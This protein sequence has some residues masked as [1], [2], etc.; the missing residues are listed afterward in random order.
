MFS[1]IQALMLLLTVRYF[2]EL[3]GPFAVQYLALASTA[4]AGVALG[5]FVSAFAGTSERAMTILPVLLIAQAILSG[6]L[7]RLAGPVKWAAMA[8]APAY[9]ALEG[10]KTS[11][12]TDLL[13]ATYPGAPGYFQAPI[14][15]TGG[16]LLLDLIALAAHFIG[17]LAAGYFVVKAKLRQA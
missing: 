11:L 9:W 17:L 13:S 7:A 1:L 6:G 14:L 2:T 4:L 12:S 8:L 5:L 3:T 16:P 15:G 10:L